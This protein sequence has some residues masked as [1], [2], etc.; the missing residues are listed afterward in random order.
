M[1]GLHRETV[2]AA[3][4]VLEERSL[5]RV[6]RADGRVHRYE[7][8]R[9]VSAE[10]QSEKPDRHQSEKPDR[11]KQDQSE[12]PDRTSP[13]KPTTTS[14]EKPTRK[15]V[16]KPGNEAGTTKAP[17]FALP[18]WISKDAWNA[19]EEMRKGNGKALKTDRAR[20]LL[21]AKLDKLRGA[22]H[23][24]TAVL[25]ESTMNSWLGVYPLK[26]GDK[27][28]ARSGF[29]ERDYTAGAV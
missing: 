6:N 1:T 16:K 5:I 25:E 26:K 18:D 27:D 9:P 4:R 21:V 15:L 11:S 13:E 23:D 19:F 22:G 20:E 7:L 10:K 3:L 28:Q 2:F 29:A 17:R 12:K 24:P 8:L 14:P